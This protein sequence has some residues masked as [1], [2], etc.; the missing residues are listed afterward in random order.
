M[1]SGLIKLTLEAQSSADQSRKSTSPHLSTV[2]SHQSTPQCSSLPNRHISAVVHWHFLFWHESPVWKKCIKGISD[3]SST[4]SELILIWSYGI[5]G[6]DPFIASNAFIFDF[7]LLSSVL[8]SHNVTLSLNWQ[9]GCS[10]RVHSVFT[11][12]FQQVWGSN[13][14]LRNKNYK[15][16]RCRT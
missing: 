10:T 2:T 3:L 6:K 1:D 4:L 16:R 8:K 5:N 14:W 7:S 13:K 9:D 12:L 15:E 11:S